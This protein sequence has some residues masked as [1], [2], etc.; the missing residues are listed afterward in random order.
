MGRRAEGHHNAVSSDML[1]E[2][3][4]NADAKEEGGLGGITEMKQAET[5]GFI[6]GM[7]LQQ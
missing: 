3:T 4:Y 7:L 6:R 1:L 2:Q 5:N